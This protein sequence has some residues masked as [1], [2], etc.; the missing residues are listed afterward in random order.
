MT[1]RNCEKSSNGKIFG[2]NPGTGYPQIWIRD[3]ATF[4]GFAKLYYPLKILETSVERFLENQYQ[5][6]EIPDWVD[7]RSEKDK[8]SVS[9]DQESSLVIAAFE[10]A[11]EK[12]MWPM[13]SIRGETIIDRLESAMEWVWQNRRDHKYQL[14]WS[15]YT[16]DWGDLEKSYPDLRAIKLSSR[17]QKTFST[18][19]RRWIG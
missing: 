13:K 5:D 14:I 1:L 15:G 17:S 2:F 4:I 10:I 6:G 16:A 8:N 9:T 3:I 18:T 12:P 19:Y 11:I 7:F